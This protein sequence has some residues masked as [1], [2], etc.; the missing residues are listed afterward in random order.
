MKILFISSIAYISSIF[1][2]QDTKAQVVNIDKLTTYVNILNLL[3]TI[4]KNLKY[5]LKIGMY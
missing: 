4:D 1:I 2:I 3:E 5:R